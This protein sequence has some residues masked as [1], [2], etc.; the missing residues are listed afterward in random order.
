MRTE[1]SGYGQRRLSRFSARALLVF[2]LA[3]ILFVRGTYAQLPGDFSQ[4][5]ISSTT[6]SNGDTVNIDRANNI[7]TFN[8]SNVSAT[9][10]S[11]PVTVTHPDG[12][13]VQTAITVQK[14]NG[15]LY[16]VTVPVA[17]GFFTCNYH[18]ATQEGGCPPFV[19]NNPTAAASGLASQMGELRSQTLAVTTII[20]DRIRSR[21]REV[22]QNLA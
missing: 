4:P 12:T 21:S 6:N 19:S 16:R 15:T 18:T 5:I 2:A 22:A 13:T 10:T 9:L 14:I 8:P 3:S 7:Y 17:G 1:P 11:V 20:S